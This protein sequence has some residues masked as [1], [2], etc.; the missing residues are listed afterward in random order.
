MG[1]K[2]CIKNKK[3]KENYKQR[4]IIYTLKFKTDFIKKTKRCYKKDLWE[5][6]IKD[7]RYKVF[8]FGKERELFMLVG[9]YPREN[10]MNY[11]IA[12][13]KKEGEKT[14]YVFENRIMPFAEKIDFL[15]EVKKIY[16][17]DLK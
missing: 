3:E 1:R 6:K 8:F 4:K 14:E 2:K 16:D 17:I 5:F 13:F 9:K 7:V 15:K 11:L 10:S 12:V